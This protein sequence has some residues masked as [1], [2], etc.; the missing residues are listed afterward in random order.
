MAGAP[1]CPSIADLQ[2]SGLKARVFVHEL[3]RCR[4]GAGL[5]YLAAVRGEWAPVAA[6]HGH[7]PV[8]LYEVLLTD[9]EVMTIWA[10]DPASHCDLMRGADGT[11][12]RIAKWRDVS[13]VSSSPTGARSS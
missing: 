7:S 6:D 8:G 9:T 13:R 12:E 4:P 2:A 3:S 1:G 5:D 10:T 11:D